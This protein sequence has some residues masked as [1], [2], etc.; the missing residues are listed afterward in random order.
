MRALN[1]DAAAAL[2]L[3][4]FERAWQR[5]LSAG[6]ATLGFFVLFST[7]G[8]YFGLAVLAVVC[9]LAPA[10]LLQ[11][12]PWREPVLASGLLL[13]TYIVLRTLADAAAPREA[14]AAINR[15]HELLMLPLLWALMHNARRPQAFVNGL[16]L[17]ALL[18]AAAHWLAPL[19]P[20]LEWFLHTRR[21]SAGFGLAVCAFLFFEHA[22]L[23][24]LPAWFG[25]G[26]A[27]FLALTVIFASSGRT[28]HFVLL[29]LLLCAS[30]RAAPRRQRLG[31]VAATLVAAGLIAFAS[32]AVRERL[33]QTWTEVRAGSTGAPALAWSRTELLRTGAVVA[34]RHWLVGT[35]WASYPQ[36]FSETAMERLG[37]ALQENGTSTSVNPHNE[38]LLQW[39]AGGLPALLLFIAWLGVPMWRAVRE[40]RADRP[41][42][43]AVGCV[44]LAL[45]IASLFNSA[46]LD[47][48]EG[49]FYAALLAW[50]LVR[51]VQD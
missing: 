47:F 35:G 34:E 3:P 27:A 15:Y 21:I 36:V 13:F 50:L 18:F 33:Q 24:R 5:A 49:H 42:A 41:W 22:R 20:R 30:F 45:A 31:V 7:A 48:V 4:W 43:G 46:L 51:R 38:Y 16:M 19:D 40:R 10:R 44:A 11:L 2:P 39:G 37:P 1:P 23:G 14:L 25:Y 8:V 17:G 29:V 6:L 9:V 32:D 12:K 28:G 26:A